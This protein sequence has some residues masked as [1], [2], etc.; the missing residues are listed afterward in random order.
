MVNV[1]PVAVCPPVVTVTDPLLGKLDGA[2]TVAVIDVALHA[3]VVAVSPLKLTVPDVPR[4]AP[5]MITCVPG[6]ALVMAVPL[7]VW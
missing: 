5:A 2:G 3:L 6:A 1:P 7:V 4:L